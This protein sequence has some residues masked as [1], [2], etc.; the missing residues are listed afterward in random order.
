MPGSRSTS[1]RPGRPGKL[2]NET[3]ARIE[4]PRDG[5]DTAGEFRSSRQRA[6]R[7]AHIAAHGTPSS[8]SETWLKFST[9]PC[10]HV[11]QAYLPPRRDTAPDVARMTTPPAKVSPRSPEELIALLKRLP[12]SVGREE[13]TSDVSVKFYQALRWDLDQIQDVITPRIM[14]YSTDQSLIDR[15]VEFDDASR[16]LNHAI[17]VHKEVLTH[18]GEVANRWTDERTRGLQSPAARTI[19]G[20]VVAHWD[21]HNRPGR[22]RIAHKSR[23]WVPLH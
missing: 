16:N 3:R 6:N 20:A 22:K 18:S 15:L 8:Q 10:R 13:S 17:I 9:T 14:Q 12:N 1:K 7:E 19:P 23:T 21:Q 4:L 11:L 5:P 2:R